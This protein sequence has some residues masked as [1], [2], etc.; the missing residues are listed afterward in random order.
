[1]GP[2]I[3]RT[4]LRS[5]ACAHRSPSL[6]ASRAYRACGKDEVPDC[7]W[8]HKRLKALVTS[9]RYS[10]ALPTPGGLRLLLCE[11]RFVPTPPYA[12]TT[13]A[14]TAFMKR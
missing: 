12:S 3:H 1:M 4:H 10:L 2:C 8:A 7:S 5:Q 13:A 11:P 14:V 6:A 9:A